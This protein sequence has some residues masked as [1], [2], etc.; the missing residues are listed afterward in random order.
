MRCF[1]DCMH[2][3]EAQQVRLRVRVFSRVSGFQEASGGLLASLETL[4]TKQNRRQVCTP[5]T[6]PLSFDVPVQDCT[7][8]CQIVDDHARPAG[9]T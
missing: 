1:A 6:T 4:A 5:C 2:V 9:L 3:S 7:C 8:L